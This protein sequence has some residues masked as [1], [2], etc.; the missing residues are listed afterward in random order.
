[1]E[2]DHDLREHKTL[3]MEKRFPE[4]FDQTE[5]DP[6]S[7]TRTMPMEVIC[8]GMM[9]TGTMSIKAA[10]EILKIPSVY[11]MNSVIKNPRDAEMWKEAADA[12]YH[13]KGTPFTREDW[14][15]LMGESAACID[16]PSA[17]FMPE[18]IAAYPEAKVIISQRDPAKWYHSVMTT[19]VKERMND[20]W[21]R[22]IAPFDT[23]F[24]RR[25]FPMMNSLLTGVFGPAGMSDKENAIN[26]Y[27]DL[28]DEV[29]RLVQ[30]ERRL[31]YR[32]GDGWEPLC[33]FLGKDVPDIEFPFV[34]ESE[35]FKDRARLMRK[36]AVVRIAKKAVP[37]VT[38]VA[39]AVSA[40]YFVRRK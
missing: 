33:E 28:H 10:L 26:I 15:Q 5:I 40:V 17:I 3:P 18:L 29:R 32:L 9:R 27:N 23:F 14:D 1:M 35:S 13:G 7:R 36:Q 8:I 12:K 20:K 24:Y 37:W 4:C 31:E 16:L 34:N 30:P 25:F 19:I 2:Q 11:H 21:T 39:V 38:A 6:R 22:R